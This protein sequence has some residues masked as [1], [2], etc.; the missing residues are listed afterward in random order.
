MVNVRK[1]T[2][3]ARTFRQLPRLTALA[4]LKNTEK[5]WKASL[6]KF[7]NRAIGQGAKRL[8]TQ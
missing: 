3:V 4:L 2:K 8:K 6:Y 5:V 1:P 7:K